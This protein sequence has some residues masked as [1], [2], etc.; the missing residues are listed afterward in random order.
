MLW[1]VMYVWSICWNCWLLH[2]SKYG[3]NY[4]YF[5][6]VCM[7]CCRLFHLFKFNDCWNVLAGMHLTRIHICWNKPVRSWKLENLLLLIFLNYL[8]LIE[9]GFYCH[10]GNTIKYPT[11]TSTCYNTCYG[12]GS[13]YCGDYG[14]TYHS[15]YSYGS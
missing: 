6:H 10:C 15:V 13:Q 11:M 2:V 5:V 4:W 3:H 9:R 12:N 1:I 8:S 7:C 14:G